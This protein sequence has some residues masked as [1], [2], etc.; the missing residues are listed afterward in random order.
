M[1]LVKVIQTIQKVEVYKGSNGSHF[2]PDTMGGAINFITDIDY[3]N[4]YTISSYNLN[5]NSINYNRTKI[6]DNGWHLNFKGAVNKLKPTAPL[7]KDRKRWSSKL[8]SKL[9]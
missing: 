7:R 4:S 1:I 2:G 3:N 9:K 8:S 5:N 6:T